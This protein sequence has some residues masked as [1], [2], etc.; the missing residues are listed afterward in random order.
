MTLAPPH[1]APSARPPRLR[2]GDEL[3]PMRVAEDLPHCLRIEAPQGFPNF[4][5]LSG[6][7]MAVV[8]CVRLAAPHL[9]GSP[10]DPKGFPFD[11]GF[12]LL[13]MAFGGAVVGFPTFRFGYTFDGRARTATRRRL[14]SSQTLPATAIRSVSVRVG[15]RGPDEV[16]VLVLEGECGDTGITFA[17]SDRRGLPLTVAAARVAQLLGV[18]VTRAGWPVQGGAEVR[19]ALDRL[20]PPPVGI[21]VLGDGRDLI[22]N[23]PACKHKHVPAVS[24]DHREKEYGVSHTSTWVKCLA[25]GTHLH[26]KVAA[27]ELFGRSPEQLESVVVFRLSLVGRATASLAV[28]LC[29]FPWVGCGMA[30]LATIINWRTRGW[31]R[32]TSRVALA[33]SAVVTVGMTI[34][35]NS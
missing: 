33:V 7:V 10:I 1:I 17:P 35:I 11:W 14:F 29:L 6:I 23:C 34:L 26:S 13:C 31:P 27:G 8:G 28:L 2:A 15:H 18:P 3:G 19:A 30:L 4:A 32:W 22:I 21:D 20:A 5:V 24:Y 16:L 9:F 12:F 25:C